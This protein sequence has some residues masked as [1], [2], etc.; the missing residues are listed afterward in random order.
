LGL[1][2][3]CTV[4]ACTS[5]GSKD[6][7]TGSGEGG[8]S[9]TQGGG[10]TGGGAGSVWQATRAE[11]I[12]ISGSDPSGFKQQTIDLPATSVEGTTGRTAEMY[13]KLEEGRLVTFARFEGDNVYY[14][15]IQPCSMSGSTCTVR[16]NDVSMQFSVNEGKLEQVSQYVVG[17][18]DI[19]TSTITFTSVAFPPSGWPTQSVTRELGEPQ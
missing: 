1:L 6:G 12:V 13:R 7:G 16:W 9:G 15:I 10:G 8:T 19:V 14:Q 17:D 5:N 11:V 4:G 18:G 3:A 2:V